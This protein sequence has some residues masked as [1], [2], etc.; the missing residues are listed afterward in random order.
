M[1]DGRRWSVAGA[2]LVAVAVVGFF[3]GTSDSDYQLETPATFWQE[4]PQGDAPVAITY[5]EAR[6][7]TNSDGSEVADEC[8]DCH[9]ERLTDLERGHRTEHPVGVVVPRNARLTELLASGGRLAQEEEDGPRT[10]VCRSCHRPHNAS[11]DA[12]FIVT[13]DEGALCVSCHFDH[14]PSRSRHPLQVRMTAATRAAIEGVGGVASGALTCLSCHD[15]HDSSV[16]TLLRTDAAGADA[17]GLCHTDQARAL[18]AR[19]H[20]AQS[21]V[22]C[23]G[24]HLASTRR[25]SGPAAPE[26]QDQGCVDCHASNKGSKKQI[27][28]TRGHPMGVDVPASGIASGHEGKVSCS[29]CHVPHSSRRSVLS[30]AGTGKLC[31]DCH[32]EQAG[33][34]GT[35]HDGSKAAVGGSDRA[36]I[37]CHDMHSRGGRPSA[38]RGVNPASG[39]CL[40]CHDGRTKA[41][42][43]GEWDHP[44]G[45]LMTTGGLP[46]RYDGPVPYFGP[47]GRPTHDREAG[48]IACQTCHDPHRWK[49]TSYDPPGAVEGTEQDSFLR[50]PKE[51]IRLCSVCHGTDGRPRFRFFHGDQFRGDEDGGEQ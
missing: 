27:S 7:L 2:V 15:P 1:S 19:G 14:R 50:A 34:V 36:C 4:S 49:S 47:D 16:G 28:L 45:L 33:V 18:G 26:P 30:K 44:E 17:C 35:D 9:P 40:A 11:E 23:H 31:V 29:D 42:K 10:V 8:S 3:V 39:R 32:E 5:L 20:G 21:C 6:V 13:T 12:R 24:M 37:T 43:V 22:D 25:G 46:F 38:P 51:V 41:K 48:Q